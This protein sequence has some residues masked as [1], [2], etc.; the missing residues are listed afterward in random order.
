MR[1]RSV[2]ILT[3]VVVLALV[4]ARMLSRG[5]TTP[6]P[7]QSTTPIVYGNGATSCGSWTI[8]RQ[9]NQWADRG[10][11]VLGWVSAA[12]VYT[13]R[14]KRT[15]A[16]GIFTWIDRYCIAHPTDELARA[17]MALIRD[18]LDRARDRSQGA[19]APGK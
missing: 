3:A 7:P 16:D 14:V 11:W 4:D 10:H 9:R 18:N 15:D 5:P 12:S 19:R 17:A 1:V 6:P 13:N 8:A 2:L